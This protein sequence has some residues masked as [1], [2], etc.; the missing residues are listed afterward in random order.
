MSENNNEIKGEIKEFNISNNDINKSIRINNSIYASQIQPD[1]PIL[2][3]LIEFGYNPIY[4]KRII[5]LLHPRDIE[6]VVDYFSINNGII[7]HHF[8]RDRNQ[9]NIFCYICGEKKENHLGYIPNNNEINIGI[10]NNNEINNNIENNNN[11]V[12]KDDI[13]SKEIII[14]FNNKDNNENNEI[15]NKEINNNNSEINNKE[16]NIN[17]SNEIN[18]NNINENENINIKHDESYNS[19]FLGNL[20]INRSSYKD[21]TDSNNPNLSKQNICPIC[22][23]NFISTN[24]NTVEKCK[25]SFCDDC[26]YN[27]LNIKIKENKLTSIKCLDYECQEKISDEFIINLLNKDEDLIKKYK[28]Y[29]LELDIINDPNKKLC[30]FPNCDSYLILKNKEFKITTC[31][32]KHTYCFF[33]LRKPHGKSPCKEKLDLSMLEFAKNNFVKRCPNCSIITEKNDG[34]NHITCTKCNYQWCWLC[35]KQYT[36]EHYIEG[37]CKGFQFYKPKN[38]NDIKLAFE[39]K[40]HLRDSQRQDDVDYPDRI[41]IDI[42][43]DFSNRPVPAHRRRNLRQGIQNIDYTKSSF[44]VTILVLFIYIIFGHAIVSLNYI[45]YRFVRNKIMNLGILGMYLFIEIA[46]FFTII[47]LNLIMLIPYLINLDF[48]RFIYISQG[49]RR[50]FHYA[51]KQVSL[52]TILFILYF[53]FGGFFN[54]LS[55]E[56]KCNNNTIYTQELAYFLIDIIYIVIYFPVQ[57]FINQ[58]VMLIILISDKCNLIKNLN[59]ILKKSIGKMFNIDD[60]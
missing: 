22:S 60:D 38:E 24:K 32:N 15:N 47:Y 30:P 28:K 45:P 42:I 25:H 8:I 27:F 11:D 53:F 9:N 18:N 7:Q 19:S 2:V 21:N 10:N 4:S 1:N 39:G 13:K 56:F 33:C 50:D 31:K 26:W 41:R 14:Q 43:D 40:I 59:Q 34:C 57:F 58:I 36:S 54:I 16:I 23:D 46:H 17:L 35:N 5:Q 12:N 48:Y 44:T 20:K 37:K 49:N 6:E 3:R 29:K 52:K 55:I 51:F